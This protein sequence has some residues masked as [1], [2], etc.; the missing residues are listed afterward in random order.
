MALRSHR[1]FLSL[2]LKIS[3]SLLFSLLPR[4]VFTVPR[5][6]FS[7][8]PAGGGHRFRGKLKRLMGKARKSVGATE[9]EEGAHKS[10]GMMKIAGDV[11]KSQLNQFVF[12]LMV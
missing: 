10:S 3:G 5:D 8:P 7:F 12:W 4:I 9:N 6:I 11:K 1:Q 2:L